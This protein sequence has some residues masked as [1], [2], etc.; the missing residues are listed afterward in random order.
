MKTY[1]PFFRGK[2]NELMALRGL[3]ANIAE[4]GNV[5]PIIEPVKGN[6][7]TRISLDKYIEDSMPF[8][9]ICNPFNGEFENQSERLYT[10][11]ISEALLE[12]DIWTPALQVQRDSPRAD[13][14]SFLERYREYEVAVIYWGL[15]EDDRVRRLLSNEQ[16][17][18]HIFIGSR[19]ETNYIAGIDV[20]RRVM[21]TD[22]FN[23][24]VRN[25]DY[26]ET[27]LFSDMN[28][29]SG[30]PARV[31]FG[32]FSMV[33]DYYT[34]TG[35]PAYAVALHHIHLRTGTGPLYINHF[36]SDRTETTADRAGKTLE[37][38]D[39]LVAALDQLMPNDT[40]ACGEY[41]EIAEDRMDRGL[42]YM[43][44][45]AIAHHLEVMLN[46]GI[47]L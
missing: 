27:E 22:R 37:A 12:Y 42:G 28:T 13:V 21:L 19:I 47:Q 10:T 9:F 16:V 44:R 20:A 33:G 29:I 35:G 6:P 23:R 40:Q 1:F 43:K 11:L 25:A 26:P 39:K 7:S 46:G 8:V 32:D 5:L 36:I 30:N 31:S 15:P 41:R 45:L 24:Q 38:V 34:E 3:G 14:A 2:L 18:W 4:R 17:R